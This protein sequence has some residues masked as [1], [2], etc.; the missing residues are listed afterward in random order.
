[1]ECNPNLVNLRQD[2]KSCH[3][4]QHHSLTQVLSG[5]LLTQHES[6]VVLGVC[7]SCARS[8]QVS[9]ALLEGPLPRVLSAH[10]PTQE[11]LEPGT[12]GPLYGLGRR[13]ETF[14]CYSPTT[15]PGSVAEPLLPSGPP[16]FL[17]SRAFPFSPGAPGPSHLC[18]AAGGTTR[19]W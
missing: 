17:S 18:R 4:F 9:D 16:H 12:A 13:E 2:S 15:D 5:P 6:S 14:R 3:Q 11:L 10:R 8:S 1:M 19:P 7:V